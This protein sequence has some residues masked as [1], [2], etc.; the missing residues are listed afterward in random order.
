LF[1]L[2]AFTAQAQNSVYKRTL[3]WKYGGYIF[4]NDF[5]FNYNSYIYY[6]GL[7]KMQPKE[8]YATEHSSHP[9]LLQLA[10]VLDEDAKE[11]GYTGLTWQ[12]I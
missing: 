2:G 10:K 12:S 1:L 8:N 11:L 3:Q 6:K 5:T 4:T 7:S 9:Y